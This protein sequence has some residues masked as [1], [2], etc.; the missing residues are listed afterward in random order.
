L[1]EP[2]LEWLYETGLML[3]FDCSIPLVGVVR[4][5]VVSLSAPCSKLINRHRIGQSPGYENPDLAPLPV[6]EIV[7]GLI[8][9]SAA[10]EEIWHGSG[11]RLWKLGLR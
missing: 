10:V 6:R 7:L 4:Q 2:L 11:F 9:L 8:D 5:P 3:F 1:I